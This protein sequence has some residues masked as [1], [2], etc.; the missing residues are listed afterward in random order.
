MKPRDLPQFAFADDQL[1]QEA[2][3]G[4]GPNPGHT[5][6]TSTEAS[7]SLRPSYAGEHF[8]S[9]PAADSLIPLQVSPKVRHRFLTPLQTSWA[10]CAPVMEVT[11]DRRFTL[12]SVLITIT[13]IIITYSPMHRKVLPR[14]EAG[15]RERVIGLEYMETHPRPDGILLSVREGVLAAGMVYSGG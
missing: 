3:A 11:H 9:W 12:I 1:S 6:S 13:I 15:R 14:S 4:P 5:A 7:S 8:W 10:S 2:A